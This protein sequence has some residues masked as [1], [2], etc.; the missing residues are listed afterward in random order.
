MN[1][2]IKCCCHSSLLLCVVVL[3][4]YFCCQSKVYTRTP[5]MY[6][7]FML[8]EGAKYVQPVPKGER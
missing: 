2:N 8:K 1:K 4:F 5:T 3:T 6:L 7:D